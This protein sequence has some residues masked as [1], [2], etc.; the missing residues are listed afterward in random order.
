AQSAPPSDGAA[1]GRAALPAVLQDHERY[2]ALQWLG[3]GGMGTVYRARHKVL[4]RTVAVKVMRARLLA[5]PQAVERF[6]REAKAAAR[7]A[8]PNI[9]A[10]HDAE[11]SGGHH[12]LVMELV[13]GVSLDRLVLSQGP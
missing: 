5:N 10:V 6:R 4:G 3:S 7:L 8:H 9:V 12:L 1:P 2:D 11:Q 13:E